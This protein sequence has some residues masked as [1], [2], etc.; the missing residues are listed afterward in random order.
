MMKSEDQLLATKLLELACSG[1]AQ[2]YSVLAKA[3]KELPISAVER[4]AEIAG[5]TI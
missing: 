2:H 5:E 3:L 1:D 4:L